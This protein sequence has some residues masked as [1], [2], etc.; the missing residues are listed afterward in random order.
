MPF[1]ELAEA[2]GRGTGV[3][4]TSVTAE[5]AAG[6]FAFL[7]SL[8]GLDNPTSSELTRKELGSVYPGLIEDLVLSHYFDQG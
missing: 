6:C 1:R 7:G 5:E 3:P 8:V 4:T 2:I